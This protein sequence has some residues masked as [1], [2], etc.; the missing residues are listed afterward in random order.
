MS[1]PFQTECP[2]LH[3]PLEYDTLLKIWISLGMTTDSVESSGKILRQLYFLRII[4]ITFIFLMILLAVLGLNIDLP[5]IPMSFILALMVATNL[6]TRHFINSGKGN[7]FYLIFIQLLLEILSFSG[8]LFYSGGATNPFT[9]FYLIPLAIAAIVIPGLPT[10]FLTALTVLLYSLLLKFYVPLG[11]QM[12]GHHHELSSDGQFSQHVFGMWFGFLVSAALVTWFITYLSKELKQRDH[13]I[14]EARQREMRDQQM[15]TLG[16]L[17]AGTAH[18]LGTPLASLAVVSGELTDGFDALEQPELF[19]NQRILR[20]QIN[21]CKKILSVLSDSAG[22]SRAEAGHLVSV[23]DFINKIM[24][25]WQHQR[26]DMPFEIQLKTEQAKGQLLYDRTISQALINLLNNAAD[27]TTKSIQIN[28]HADD[29]ALQLDIQDSGSGM[30][31]EQI[32]LAGDVSFSSKPDGMGIGLFLA[33]TTIRRSGGSVGFQRLDTAGTSSII[34]LP[35][36]QSR[37]D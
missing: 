27:A 29:Q 22:E 36:I 1:H 18:E 2:E 13:A 17:A 35:L 37:H 31:D 4:T 34:N 23:D 3:N 32:A 16:T 12:H 28:A 5:V 7:T 30:S 20:D 26:P 19:E 10:W 8:I 24:D 15:V 25:Q 21:R 9:F 33:I 14:A 11:Y 6:I